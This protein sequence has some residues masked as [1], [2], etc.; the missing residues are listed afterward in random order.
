MAEIRV[1]EK[2]GTNWLSTL[3]ALVIAAA[4]VWYFMMRRDDTV[5]ATTVPADSVRPTSVAPWAPPSPAVAPGVRLV[6]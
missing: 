1:E 6:A 4:L 2:R 3:L 5:P